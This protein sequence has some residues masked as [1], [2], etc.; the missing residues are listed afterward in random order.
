MKSGSDRAHTAAA[1]VLYVGT[2]VLFVAA[3]V[4]CWKTFRG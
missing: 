3:I 1:I 4:A 2:P